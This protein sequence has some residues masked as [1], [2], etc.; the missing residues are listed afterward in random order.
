MARGIKLP[1]GGVAVFDQESGC[2]HRCTTC[3]AMIGS[4]GQPRRCVENANK[5]STIA[6]LGGKDWDYSTVEIADFDY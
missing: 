6:A 5:Y 3:F 4:V 2:G 1:C